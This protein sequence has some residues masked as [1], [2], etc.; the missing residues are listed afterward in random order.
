MNVFES[1]PGLAG[2]VADSSE[3][4]LPGVKVKIIDPTSTLLVSVCTDGDGFY[5]YCYKHT[6]REATYT[7]CLPLYSLSKSAPLEADRFVEVNFR[8]PS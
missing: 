5:S 2:M 7:V 1:D 6:G 3:T 4:P 8:M